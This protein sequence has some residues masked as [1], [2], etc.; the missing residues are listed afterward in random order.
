MTEPRILIVDDDPAIRRM[1]E[2]VACCDG[3]VCDAA[4]NGAEGVAAIRQN[5]YSAVFLDIMMPRVDGWGVLDFLRA[6][7]QSRIRSLFMI[8]ATVD[9]NLSVGD[10]ELVTGIL[11]K[12]LHLDDVAALIRAS[13]RGAS[14]AGVLQH[15]RHQLVMGYQ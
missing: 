5:S 12:P 7:P 13:A 4:C 3:I 6:R 2:L 11:Y 15:T 10:R 14:A 9:Q 8:T 1:F